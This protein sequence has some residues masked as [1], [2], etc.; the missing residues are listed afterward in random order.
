MPDQV[1]RYF[2]VITAG[3]VEDISEA[4]YKELSHL[5]DHPDAFKGDWFTCDNIYGGECRIRLSSICG[6]HETS[7]ETQLQWRETRGKEQKFLRENSDYTDEDA[8]E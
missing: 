4:D 3:S 2:Q 5:L 1:D 7:P 8:E 6:I